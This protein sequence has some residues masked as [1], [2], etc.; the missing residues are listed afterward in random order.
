MSAKNLVNHWA[1]EDEAIKQKSIE[2][3]KNDAP[4]NAC[5]VSIF[6]REYYSNSPRNCFDVQ[7][8]SF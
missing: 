7:K 4:L 5:E 1:E 3:G 2:K 8:S 6:D